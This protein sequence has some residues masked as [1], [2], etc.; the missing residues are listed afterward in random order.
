MKQKLNEII[1]DESTLL[2]LKAFTDSCRQVNKL[3]NTV[4]KAQNDQDNIGKEYLAEKLGTTK[5]RLVFMEIRADFYTIEERNYFLYR[6]MQE[7]LA[8]A[9]WTNKGYTG[10][11]IENIWGSQRITTVTVNKEKHCLETATVYIKDLDAF[12]LPGIEDYGKMVASIYICCKKESLVKVVTQV[13]KWTNTYNLFK[14]RC[15]TIGD[16]LDIV[17]PVEKFDIDKVVL[18][19]ELKTE[20]KL[21]CNMFEKYTLFKDNSIAFKRGILLVGQPGIGKSTTINAVIKNVLAKGG[22]IFIVASTQKLPIQIIYKMA[23]NYGPSLVVLEDYDLIAGNRGEPNAFNT[24][25]SSLLNVL[26]GSMSPEN[27]ITIA[28]TNRLD[29]LDEAA[30]RPGRMDNIYEMRV[31]DIEMKKRLIEIHL[32]Y[33]KIG[34]AAEDVINKLGSWLEDSKITGALIASKLLEVKQRAL[35]EQR[36]VVLEDFDFK[37]KAA[38]SL[39]FNK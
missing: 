2:A 11:K 16:C 21:I 37:I 39:G 25:A 6:L 3:Y 10:K 24:T 36:D 14:G 7:G 17:D 31:P 34:L 15:T 18:A 9:F 27:V 5:D 13:E 19:N 8:T 35:I 12:I 28:T 38:F 23:Q 29:L 26:D 30:K 20:I 1:L 22:T 4:K 33:Y 32:D